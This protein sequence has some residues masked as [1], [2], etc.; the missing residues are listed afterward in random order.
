MPQEVHDECG[1]A[2][3]Y[4]KDGSK[5]ENKA[6]FYLYKL[7]LNLQNRGQ[8]SAGISTFNKG[9]RQMLDT[10]KNIGTVNEVFRTSRKDKSIQ[11]FRKYAGK[12]GIGHVRYATF[13]KDERIYAQPFERHH[14]RLWKWFSF[15]FNG[16]LVNYTK[17]KETLEKKAEYHF[18]LENDTEI[19][20]HYIARELAGS[21]R[22]DLKNVFS[23]LTKKFEGAYNIAFLNARGSLAALRDPLGFRPLSYAVKDGSLLVASES[24]ALVNC[25]YENFKSL[26]PGKMISVEDD[27]I[28]I[29][30]CAKCP[31]KAHCMFE[32]VYFSNVSSVLD[33]KSVYIAR[34]NLGRELAKLETE[35]ITKDHIAVPVPDSAKAAGDSFA[36]ELG[37][38]TRE[39]LIRNRFVG[40]TFIEG[41][42]RKDK[43]QN[44]YTMVR[45]VLKGKKVLLVDDSIV[46]GATTE[47][48]VQSLK[49]DGG[50]KEVHVRVSCPPIMGPC[51]YGIDMST[52]T[53]LIAPKFMK[54]PYDEMPQKSAEKMAKHLG[55][56]SVIYQ[57][58]PGLVRSI[59]LPRK[60]LCMAC[61][62]R[63]YP[64]PLGKKLMGVALDNFRKGRKESSRLYETATK[65]G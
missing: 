16:N 53:E 4:L 50:A 31:R 18:I 44:K 25:G 54:E 14:G 33:G 12:K 58:I 23:N 1:V 42:S 11:L 63:Y 32:W 21:R 29:K 61:L 3:V 28:S 48:L 45:E 41:S 10:Y 22:P 13:G 27:N 19:L 51:F 6:L 8:L 52:V 46:R 9:R 5:A 35:K 49:E 37:V 38:P 56:D 30:R 55:A 64:T 59:G 20:M 43:V 47:Q 39:G 2:A 36:Y 7:L 40:R 62:N 65:C 26:E 24:N 17:L 34:T 15:C 60:D 57:S